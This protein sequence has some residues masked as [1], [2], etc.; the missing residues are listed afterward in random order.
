MLGTVG[1]VGVAILYRQ[2][3]IAFV[4]SVDFFFLILS[5]SLRFKGYM[6]TFLQR[7]LSSLLIN[8]ICKYQGHSLL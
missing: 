2:S 7:N 3:R 1:V 4:S 6:Y 5:C 8:C